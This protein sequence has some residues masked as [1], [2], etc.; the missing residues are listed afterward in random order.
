MIDVMVEAEGV[1]I[2]DNSDVH[3]PDQEETW[4]IKCWCSDHRHKGVEAMTPGMFEG[5]DPH[6]VGITRYTLYW[7]VK[8]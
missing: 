6:V 4:F 1:F 3:Q 8:K 5:V 7:E 2:I